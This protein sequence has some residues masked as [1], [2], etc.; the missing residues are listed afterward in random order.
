MPFCKKRTFGC[1]DD[2]E[3]FKVVWTINSILHVIPGICISD[4]HSN[5]LG[6]GVEY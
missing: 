6:Q 4:S 2:L 1:N 5:L 3:V